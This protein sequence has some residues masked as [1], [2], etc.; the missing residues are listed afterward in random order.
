MSRKVDLAR[1]LLQAGL[2]TQARF[3]QL[4]VHECFWE[5]RARGVAPGDAAEMV[6]QA[7]GVTEETVLVYCRRRD[8]YAALDEEQPE[9]Q[10]SPE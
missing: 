2:I 6:S 1:R 10:A 4:Q 7:Y 9:P 5:F 3:R 8:R